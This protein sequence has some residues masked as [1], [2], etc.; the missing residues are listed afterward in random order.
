[1][2]QLMLAAVRA[3]QPRLQTLI[4]LVRTM[5]PRQ[6]IKNGFVFV[7]LIFDGQLFPLDSAPF[8]RTV[9]G[10][11]LLCLAA[12]AVYLVNDIADIER[13]KLHPEKRNRP[14]PSGQLTV[15][16]AAVAAVSLPL[17]ALGLGYLLEP[18]FALVLAT[19]LLLQLAYSFWLKN[20]VIVD[21]LVIAAGYVL[22]VAAGVALIEVQRF[23]PW[24]YL[25]TTLL[26]LFLAVGK[27]R[28]ELVMLATDAES[29]RATYREYNQALLDQMLNVVTTSTLVVYALYTFEAA[30][31]AENRAMMLTIPFVTYGLFRYLYL[32]HVRGEGGAPDEVVLT[33]RPLQ[34]DLVLWG[35]VIVF[36]IYILPHNGELAALFSIPPG[37]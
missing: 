5:R 21:V 22:R 32:I 16:V 37:L 36:V 33:D 23:S 34:V 13:D 7:P 30:G 17:V 4:A 6:W 19:Y 9:V 29:H 26:A 3:A 2:S 15:R 28:Q 24:M 20:V 25:F 12:G 8:L 11:A 31:I 1:M 10:A 27:R 14:L 18:W 35:I